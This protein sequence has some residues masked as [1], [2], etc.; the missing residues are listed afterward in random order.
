MRIGW[1]VIIVRKRK[2]EIDWIKY[3]TSVRSIFLVSSLKFD[4]F[5]DRGS[6]WKKNIEKKHKGRKLPLVVLVIEFPS[7][8]RPQSKLARLNSLTRIEIL[9]NDRFS[10]TY[11]EI[12]WPNASFYKTLVKHLTWIWDLDCVSASFEKSIKYFPSC[13]NH[14]R[15]SL[16]NSSNRVSTS[17]EISIR[18]TSALVSSSV[19]SAKSDF[20][21]FCCVHR[22][23]L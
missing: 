19:I 9:P 16:V 22:W 23:S 6:S 13:W 7:P 5:T 20:P 1:S 10:L 15:L 2:S 4:H 3:S 21:C 17:C 14:S 8:H 12:R 11:R 18:Q